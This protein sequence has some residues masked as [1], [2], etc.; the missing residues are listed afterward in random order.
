MTSLENLNHLE[1]LNVVR[2]RLDALTTPEMVINLTPEQRRAECQRAVIT[3]TAQRL[4]TKKKQR[5]VEDLA[6][7]LARARRESNRF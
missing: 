4:S 7:L 5:H 6:I 3:P 1:F 2:A